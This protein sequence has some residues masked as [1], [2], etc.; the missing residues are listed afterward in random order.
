MQQFAASMNAQRTTSAAIAAIAAIAAMRANSA[1]ERAAQRLQEASI[2]V[3]AHEHAHVAALGKGVIRYVTVTGPDGVTYAVGGSVSVD[4]SPVPG[5]PEATLRKARLAMQAAFAV[6]Q[7]SAADM[8]VAADAYR[9]E[10]QAQR[11]RER[12][13]ERG[14]HEWSA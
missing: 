14:G 13:Q 9:L 10:M 4:L 7:P 8:R 3:S 11:E 1:R 12:E 5:D 6:G 2:A